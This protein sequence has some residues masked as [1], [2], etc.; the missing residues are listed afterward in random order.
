MLIMFRKTLAV[1]LFM[2]SAITPAFA[3]NTK[4]PAIVIPYTYEAARDFHEG[5]AAVKS[6][7]RWGYIDYQI[8]R[9]H[10]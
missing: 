9:A 3:A 1:F 8:G 7:D 2:F 10:V 6:R 4:P 5:L